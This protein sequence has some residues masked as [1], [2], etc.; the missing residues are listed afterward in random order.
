MFIVDL[1]VV[2]QNN[3][4]HQLFWFALE[5]VLSPMPASTVH[6]FHLLL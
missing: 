4:M 6:I 2:L 1:F 3:L 5:V